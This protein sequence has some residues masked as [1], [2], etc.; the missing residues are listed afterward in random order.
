VTSEADE[1]RIYMT[2]N[3]KNRP[4]DVYELEVSGDKKVI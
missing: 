4:S 3:I 1:M 2:V